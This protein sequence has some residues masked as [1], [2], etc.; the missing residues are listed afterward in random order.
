MNPRGHAPPALVLIDEAAWVNQAA[1]DTPP[2]STSLVLA[3]WRGQEARVSALIDASIE[4]ASARG[5]V[6]AIRLADYARALLCNGL[7]RYD[8]ALAAAAHGCDHGDT[9][10]ST[11]MLGELVEASVRSGRLD[12]AATAARGLEQR[13][14]ASARDWALGIQ[15]Q[16]RALLSARDDAE[17]FYTEALERLGGG[18]IALHHARTQLLYG[19]WLRRRRR[20]VHAR[21]QLRAAHAT[22]TRARA[23]GFAERAQRELSA[24]G[25]RARRR[26]VETRDELTAQEAQ[27]ARLAGDG[28]TNPEIGTELFISPRTVEWHLRKVF[29]K[30][31]IRSRRQLRGLLP[32]VTTSVRGGDQGLPQAR[33]PR[34]KRERDRNAATQPPGDSC[35]PPNRSSRRPPEPSRPQ[36]ESPTR[37]AASA[38]RPRTRRR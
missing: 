18:G 33:P 25:A 11:W 9:G 30:L 26:V 2:I 35:S 27:I 13:T 17:I 32:V 19:E 31:G 36:M 29:T 34:P 23:A 15:A 7:S 28:H 1:G 22:F 21:E 4:D 37:T 24:T 14:R 6:R 3:A 8:D 5:A 10:L 20:R 16:S 38:T 12:I